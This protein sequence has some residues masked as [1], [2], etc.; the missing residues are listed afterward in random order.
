[1]SA[2][3]PPQIEGRYVLDNVG[4]RQVPVI[5][6]SALSDRLY[7]WYDTAI[8]ANGRFRQVYGYRDSL[9]DGTVYEYGG[10]S[11]YAYHAAFDTIFMQVTS[12]RVETTYVTAAGIR[13]PASDKTKWFCPTGRCDYFFR[14]LP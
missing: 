10:D 9:P 5:A 6:L 14:R 2:P 7:I 1:M 13:A 4:G 11:A 3:K 12:A 8:V